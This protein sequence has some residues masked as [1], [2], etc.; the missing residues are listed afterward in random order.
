MSTATVPPPIRSAASIGTVAV[1]A[2]IGALVF[3][4]CLGPAVLRPQALEWIFQ[5]GIDP[6]ANFMGWHMFR[7]EP[8]GVPPGVLRAYGYPVG[9]SVGLTDALPIVAIPL[10]LVSSLLPAHFQ[11]LGIWWLSCYVLL[12][13][14]GALLIATATRHPGLQLLGAA[15]FAISPP[16]IHRMGHASLSAHWLLAASLWLHLVVRARGLT[17]RLI[18]GWSL[19]LVIAAGTTPYLAAMV[20]AMAIPTIV[21]AVQRGVL[22]GSA[23]A[24]TFGL[25]TLG[26]WWTSGHFQVRGVSDLQAT[27]F[28]VLSTNLAAP[29]YPP[30]QSLMRRWLHVDLVGPDQLEGY[31][32]LGLG[33]FFLVPAAIAIR[34]SRIE[35]PRTPVDLAFAVVMIGLALFAISSTVTLGSRVLFQYDPSWWGPLTTFRASARFIWPVYYAFV[36]WAVAAVVRHARPRTA[37]L[38]LSIAL[39]LQIVDLWG[40]MGNVRVSAPGPEVDRLPSPFWQAVLPRYRHLVLNPTNMCSAPGAGFD[41]RYFALEAGEAR[42]TINAGYAPRYD[43]EGLTSYCRSFA[44]E[45]AARRVQDDTLYVVADNLV[46]LME[47]ADRPVRCGRV[48]GFAVCFTVESHERWATLFDI[49]AGK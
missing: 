22:R 3:L 28:G 6:S 14:F 35:W 17:P 34:R 49:G 9:S 7:A 24:L 5:W 43:V 21:G 25:V 39:A 38:A 15:L 1:A 12:A 19:L 18:A 30:E 36:F 45:T 8:W 27:G 26:M 13:V 2:I 46:P 16:L 32:Y 33:L 48:D 41:Y 44:A 29:F 47:S 42:V 40:A 23:V 20:A 10:K 4:R 31:C 37:A 11:Y